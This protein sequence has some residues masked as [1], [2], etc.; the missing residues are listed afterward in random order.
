VI[1]MNEFIIIFISMLVSLIIGAVA[2]AFLGGGISLSYLR[3]KASKGK[4]ILVWVDTPVG[5]KCHIG[6]FENGL[7][8][9]VVSWK[10]LGKTKLFSFDQK[11]IGDFHAVKYMSINLDSPVAHDLTSLG[12]KPKSKI[13]MHEFNHLLT[14][15]L[16]LPTVD[17]DVQAK[18]LK[19]ILICS[20]I[21]VLGVALL[22]FKITELGQAIANLGVI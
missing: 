4:K 6:T 10:Y 7:K 2:M 15:A 21:A 14:R 13:D 12:E 8:E 17:E 19:I 1:I 16:T 20:V 22:F 9:G 18:I 3:V 11:S 5:R